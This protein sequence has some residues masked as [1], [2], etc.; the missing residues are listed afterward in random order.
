MIYLRNLLRETIF[1]RIVLNFIFGIILYQ[2]VCIKG[3][4]FFLFILVIQ[5][6]LIITYKTNIINK[7]NITFNPINGIFVSLI[8]MLSSFLLCYLKDNRNNLYYFNSVKNSQLNIIIQS[9]ARIT[10]IGTSYVGKLRTNASKF[11]IQITLSDTT[12]HL[13][14][15]D[16]LIVVN[17]TSSIDS[18]YLI[19]QFNFKNYLANKRIYHQIVLD[20]QDIIK[21]KPY[22]SSDI[23]S[24]SLDYKNQLIKILRSNVSDDQVFNLAAALLLGERT[25]IDEEIVKSYSDTGTIHI[26]SVSGLH[27]GI[28]FIILQKI[29]NIIPYVKRSKILNTFIVITSI[30]FYSLLTGLPASVVRSSI[31]ISFMIIGKYINKKANPINHV[32]ASAL[33]MLS[34]EPNYLFDIGFQLSY[35]AVIGILYLQKSIENIIQFKNKVYRS[36]WIMCSVSISA[37]LFTLPLC[38]FYFHRFPNYFL[39]ANIIAIPLS[40]IALYSSVAMLIFSGIPYLNLIISVILTL[41]ITLLNSFLKFVSAIPGAVSKFEQL[42]IVSTTLFTLILIFLILYVKERQYRSLKFAFICL[43]LYSGV[44]IYTHLRHNHL[45]I[46]EFRKSNKI[47]YSIEKK[48]T[49]IHYFPLNSK[50]KEIDYYL[51]NWQNFTSKFNKVEL[52]DLSHTDFNKQLKSYHSKTIINSKLTEYCM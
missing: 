11:K 7:F 49:I 36:I 24:A 13:K 33:F 40:S 42:D 10:R 3:Q 51:N 43:I 14:Y 48:D 31:M 12:I 27:V 50:Q 37:Q 29:L 39:L 18:S 47:I 23:L 20:E 6:C 41:S 28:I 5:V 9:E 45:H 19:G 4:H 15:G 8:V 16:T 26:I 21:I 44:S 34:Y 25:Q 46:F 35:L 52:M 30:W 22:R 1:M 17:K 2:I 32:A 38:L